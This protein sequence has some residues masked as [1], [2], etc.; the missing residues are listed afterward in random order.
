[1]RLLFAN[2]DYRRRHER[3]IARMLLWIITGREQLEARKI[4]NMFEIL[5]ERHPDLV[6][7][8]DKILRV[9]EAYRKIGEYERAW[10][11][12]RAKCCLI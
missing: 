6:I 2:P 1:M 11:V 8:F 3:D 9:G 7:P 4:V 12:F 5:R 10:L